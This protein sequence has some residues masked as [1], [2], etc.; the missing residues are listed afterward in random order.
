MRKNYA[1]ILALLATTGNH[2][3]LAEGL[4]RFRIEDGIAVVEGILGK[5]EHARTLGQLWRR[6]PHKIW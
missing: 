4:P 1:L 3:T 5:A 6:D 2:R